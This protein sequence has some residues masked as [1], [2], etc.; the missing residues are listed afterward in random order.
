MKQLSNPLNIFLEQHKSE[1]IR[2]FIFQIMLEINSIFDNCKVNPNNTVS[3]LYGNRA[4]SLDTDNISKEDEERSK[5]YGDPMRDMGPINLKHVDNIV[6]PGTLPGYFNFEY[7]DECD[8][9]V[10]FCSGWIN[11]K[12]IREYFSDNFRWVNIIIGVTEET[13]ICIEDLTG[14]A[15]DLTILINV[16]DI[17]NNKKIE[18]LLTDFIYKL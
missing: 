13:E 3:N 12:Q 18:F 1:I 8:G 4:L 16:K 11:D 2:L 6:N 9:K 7:I 17:Y 10:Y 5:P 14:A 15:E